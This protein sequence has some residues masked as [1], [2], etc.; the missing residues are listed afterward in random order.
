MMQE[1]YKY[2][3]EL[4]RRPEFL[5][6]LSKPLAAFSVIIVV[7]ILARLSHY[8]T[9]YILSRILLRIVKKTKNE[10][11][12]I[13]LRKKVFNGLAHLVPLFIIYSSCFFAT[14]LLDRPISEISTDMAARMTGD[15]YLTLGPLLLKFARIYL[16]FTIVYIFITLLNAGNEIYLTTPYAYHRPIK[17]YIQLLQILIIFLAVILVISVL[18]GKDPTV[19]IAGLGAMAA[20]LMLVFKDTILGFVASIQLSANDMVKIGDWIEMPAHRADGTVADITLTTVKIQNWDKTITTV[21]T[22][23]LVS[24]SFINWKGMEQSEGRR[25]K[26]SIFID[27]YSIRFCTPEMLERFSRFELIRDYIIEREEEIRLYNRMKNFSDEDPV[28]GRRQT[29]L[30]VFRKYLERYLQ[31]NPGINQDM[32]FM[33]RQLQ[34]TDK[35]VPL[36]VYVFSNKKE[37]IEYEG[38]Q[39]DIFDHIFAVLPE[40]ELK[41]FQTPSGSDARISML[42]VR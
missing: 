12:D 37:W 22:Y 23:A 40:F 28:S 8:F 29:N 20:V 10:W 6:P 1:L 3:L 5:E 16:I 31:N 41:V 11:D 34:S 26:R 14:P 13:L 18:V 27:M 7:L 33:V 9:K 38:L 42:S 19:L 24:E 36:E 17:G 21:P 15:Y 25:I 35:G 4:F 32:S 39:S 30:G 2:L